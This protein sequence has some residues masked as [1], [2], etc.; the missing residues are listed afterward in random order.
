MFDLIDSTIYMHTKCMEAAKFKL[1]IAVGKHE[2]ILSL[3]RG[4]DHHQS[5]NPCNYQK[6][7]DFFDRMSSAHAQDLCLYSMLE[8]YHRR[9]PR[10]HLT[11]KRIKESYCRKVKRKHDRKKGRSKL[12]FFSPI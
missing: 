10:K 4:D 2:T 11:T 1:K 12:N 9:R 3:F 7:S 8:I 6:P 5:I